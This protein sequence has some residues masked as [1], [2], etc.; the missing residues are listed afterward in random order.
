[1][2]RFL[3]HL[4]LLSLLLLP[5]LGLCQAELVNGHL[6]IAGHVNSCTDSGT[7]NTYSC[8]LDRTLTQYE[9]RA[10]YGFLAN[11]TNTGAAT[12]NFSS[13]GGSPMGAKAIVKM[14]GGVTTALVANDIRTG[15]IVHVC[16][17]GTNMQMMSQPG[18]AASGSGTVNSGTASRVAYYTGATAVS[19]STGLLLDGTSVTKRVENVTASAASLTL[20][21]HNVIACDATAANR[22]YTLPAVSGQTLGQI[23]RVI[24][25]DSSSN[26]CG[27][28][29]APGER[30]NGV[31]DAS[32][33]TAVQF[34]DLEALLISTTTPNWQVTGSVLATSVFE[35][36][37]TLECVPDATALTT[38]DGQCYFPIHPTLA[39]WRVVG[40]SGHVGAAVSSSGAVTFDIDVCGAVATGVRCSGTNRD[41]LVTNGT[42]DAN[43]DGTDTAAVAAVIDTANDDLAAGE[44]LRWNLDA[45]G[46]GTQ[47]FYSTVIMRK[48]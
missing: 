13:V 42:I 34:E 12:V 1:M 16:Y 38:G 20:G 32:K 47:G 11:S 35:K 18:T 44:W 29:P 43:E 21:T 5:S 30:L 3:V 24:K 39:G 41:L 36:Y 22:T 48:P 10:C 14:T 19:E 6:V 31:V 27:L 37:V 15:Q 46:T 4:T 7:V 17:D 8:T 28:L 45:V 9:P 2:R 26:T 40:V 25:V 23:Y 33:T